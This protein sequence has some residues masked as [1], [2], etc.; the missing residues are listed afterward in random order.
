M[1]GDASHL[2]GRHEE[3]R[4]Y[5]RNVEEPQNILPTGEPL[6]IRSR[7]AKTAQ[8]PR[9]LP[10]LSR[11]GRRSIGYIYSHSESG[12][13]HGQ[14]SKAREVRGARS[15]SRDRSATYRSVS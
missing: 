15:I 4:K 9:T 5:R 7:T 6:A 3:V 13:N 12:F 1:E 14:A 8:R 2:C 11:R 10:S